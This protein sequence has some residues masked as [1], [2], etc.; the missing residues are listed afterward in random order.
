[1]RPNRNLL[2]DI[3]RHWLWTHDLRNENVKIGH[4]H[5]SPQ[6]QIILRPIFI[7]ETILLKYLFLLSV[8]DK[9]W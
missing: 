6:Q 7:D 2:V 5:S 9:K 8:L 3:L 4:G 1:M